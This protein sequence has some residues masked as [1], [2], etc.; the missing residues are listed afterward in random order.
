MVVDRKA[1]EEGKDF[2]T[3]QRVKE[4][5]ISKYYTLFDKTLFTRPLKHKFAFKW[6]R[7]V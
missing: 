5:D 7:N 3:E 2:Q 4:D 1:I 6:T